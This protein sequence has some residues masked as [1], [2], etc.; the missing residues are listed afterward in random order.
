VVGFQ[1]LDL[2]FILFGLVIVIGIL[3]PFI[4][5]YFSVN[6]YLKLSTNDLYF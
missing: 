3:I 2:I 4:S 1:N 6:K 5:T